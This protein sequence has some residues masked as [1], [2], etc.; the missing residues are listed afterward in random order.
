MRLAEAL[1]PA[2][3]EAA[4]QLSAQLSMGFF[5]PFCVT[6]FALLARI[7]VC[8]PLP[9][10]PVQLLDIEVVSKV[11]YKSEQ[12]CHKPLVPQPG[13]GSTIAEHQNTMAVFSGAVCSAAYV[14]GQMCTMR[15]PICR[16]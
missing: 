6:C 2:L 1:A 15:V 8:A 3:L 4:S 11:Q 16:C 14:A 13:I 5:V 10:E 9:F 12:A 7:Q